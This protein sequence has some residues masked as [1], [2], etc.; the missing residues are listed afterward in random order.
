MLTSHLARRLAPR[1]LSTYSALMIGLGMLANPAWSASAADLE[2][3]LSTLPLPPDIDPPTEASLKQGLP[4]KRLVLG[5]PVADGDLQSGFGMRRHPI[6]RSSK[7]HTGVDWSARF[8][9]PILS[10]GDGTVIKAE[11]AAGY[12]RRVEIQHADGVVTAYSHMSRFGTDIAPG[13]QVRQGQVIGFVGSTGLSTGPHLH[14][15]V[16][17]NGHFVDPMDIYVPGGAS[18][19]A[20]A[21]K[22]PSPPTGQAGIVPA[23]RAAALQTRQSPAAKGRAAL[24]AS[25]AQPP[26]KA[27]QSV[28]H[29]PV[30][31]AGAAPIQPLR[32]NERWA[33]YERRMRSIQS[34][35]TASTLMIMR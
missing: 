31:Q 35:V 3:V 10:A 13:T 25:L 7:M 19:A 34:K 4:R 11:W 32:R 9:A 5:K 17:V 1:G 18:V 27:V 20:K 12:G 30:R 28:K 24:A 22:T 21:G 33:E 29:A 6:F 15:E 23:E 14:Y 8:G 2:A 26:L 16:V